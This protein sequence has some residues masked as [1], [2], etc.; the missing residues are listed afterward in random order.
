MPLPW[1]LNKFPKVATLG[2]Q[3][4]V[5]EKPT[6]VLLCKENFLVISH[7]YTV[8]TVPPYIV[9]HLFVKAKERRRHRMGSQ[10][11]DRC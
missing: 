8:Y 9:D 5:R 3:Y 10:V 1:H 6:V 4:N 2:Q 7:A 11:T